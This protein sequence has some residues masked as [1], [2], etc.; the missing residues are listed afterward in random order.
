MTH[1]DDDSSNRLYA[2]CGHALCWAQLLEQE[3]LNGILLH[4]V[5]R[6]VVLT[7]AQ[8]NDL[9]NQRDKA[10]LRRKLDE[11]FKR[12][13]T[14]PDLRP[15]FYEAVEKRNFFVH[16]FFWDRF[17]DSL[18]PEGRERLIVE[19]R[20]YAELFRSAYLFSRGITDLY[21]EQANITDEA[22]HQEFERVFPSE[23][24]K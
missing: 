6:K 7:Q 12:V 11:V 17:E 24:R 16:K 21:R 19:V 14:E 8:A 20:G 9:L 22:L 2:L 18:T 4:A 3:I 15:T 5:V 23:L 13:K 1:G 10:P